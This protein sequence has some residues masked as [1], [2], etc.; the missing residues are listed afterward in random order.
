MSILLPNPLQ[1]DCFVLLWCYVCVLSHSSR[2]R[3]FATPCT[4]AHQ[5]FLFMEFSRQEYW[6]EL[7]CP[8]PGDL[9]NPGILPMSLMSP[10]LA[11]RFFTLAP[12][13]KPHTCDTLRLFCHCLYSLLGFSQPPEW[14]FKVY[15]HL[16]SLCAVCCEVLWV[17]PKSMCEAT[18]TVL[19]RRVLPP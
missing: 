19:R 4:I 6:S 5:V 3:L 10:V 12:P 9:P 15:I 11:G 17:F 7:P 1:W 8:P 2:V 14:F 16:G 18:I 13:G